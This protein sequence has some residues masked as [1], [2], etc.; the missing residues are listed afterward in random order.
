M[1]VAAVGRRPRPD[2]DFTALATVQLPLEVLYRFPGDGARPVTR[3]ADGAADPHDVR[4]DPGKN[5][6]G[7]ILMRAVHGELQSRFASENRARGIKQVDERQSSR[8]CDLL[9]CGGVGL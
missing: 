1:A 5:I 3:G 9:H 2:V 4:I 8:L 7:V 6:A